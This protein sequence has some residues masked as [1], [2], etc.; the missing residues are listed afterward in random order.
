MDMNL[1][2]LPKTGKDREAWHAAVHGA[3]KSRIWLGDWTTNK[4][5]NI[6]ISIQFET[7][8]ITLLLS[9]YNITVVKTVMNCP[10]YK[11]IYRI[12]I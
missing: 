1:S 3:A 10:E 8:T 9:P 6:F 11:D 7:A 4:L 5:N 2:K 12:C